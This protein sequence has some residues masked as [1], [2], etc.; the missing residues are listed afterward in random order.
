MSGRALQRPPRN[1]DSARLTPSGAT[2]KRFEHWA[3][4][5]QKKL[6][7]GGV[8]ALPI[9]SEKTGDTWVKGVADF[10]G[11]CLSYDL[12]NHTVTTTGLL[13]STGSEGTY[14]DRRT[15]LTRAIRPGP[16]AHGQRC[17]YVTYESWVVGPGVSR[18]REDVSLSWT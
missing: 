4:A 9:V 11:W 3:G 17:V 15:A 2:K 5:P 14:E 10:M 16:L 18:R 8:P 12:H 13:L 6:S 1:C 7:A